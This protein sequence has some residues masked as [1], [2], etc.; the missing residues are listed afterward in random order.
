MK[1]TRLIEYTSYRIIHIYSTL[2]QHSFPIPRGTTRTWSQW[3]ITIHEEIKEALTAYWH[4]IDDTFTEIKEAPTDHW[5]W[6][7]DTF[8]N[9]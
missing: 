6:M 2:H 9:T 4:W 3:V 8:T 7:D 5:H 1:V